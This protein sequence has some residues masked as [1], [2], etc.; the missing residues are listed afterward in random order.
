MSRLDS[1]LPIYRSIGKVNYDW[2]KIMDKKTLERH[3]WLSK[4]WIDLYSQNPNDMFIRKLSTDDMI[5][6]KWFEK[7]GIKEPNF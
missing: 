5:K 3:K 6:T 4:T 2:E 1:A 7:Y